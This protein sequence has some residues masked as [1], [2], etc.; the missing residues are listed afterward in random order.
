MVGLE[1]RALQDAIR[2]MRLE[3]G[4]PIGST[5]DRTCPGYFVIIDAADFDKFFFS[6]LNR[7]ISILAV[8]YKVK[9]SDELKN[10]LGQLDTLAGR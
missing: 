7:G 5:S 1:T 6:F 8:A 3:H 10:I 9:N 2:Y 4:K